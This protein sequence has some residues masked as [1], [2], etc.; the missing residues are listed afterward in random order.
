MKKIVQ[1]LPNCT[2]NNMKISIDK[3]NKIVY[4]IKADK[5]VNTS[6][7]SAAGSAPHLG[8]GCRRFDSCHSD[9]NNGFISVET[10]IFL[11]LNGR[12]VEPEKVF[13]LRKRYSISFLAK[14]GWRVPNFK[15]IGSPSV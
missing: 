1:I 15:E 6:G 4:T 12:R 13:A 11:F 8:C 3:Q 5:K 2:K 9:Q 14:S 7:C 10:V